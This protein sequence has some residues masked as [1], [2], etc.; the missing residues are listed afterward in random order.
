MSLTNKRSAA[1]LA[2][3]THWS[4]TKK[5]RNEKQTAPEREVIEV[6]SDSE[7]EKAAVTE[8]TLAL[9]ST[10]HLLHNPSYESHLEE[11]VNKD[12]IKISDLIGSQDLRESYQFNFTVQLDLILQYF[13]K[14]VSIHRKRITFITGSTV[15]DPDNPDIDFI[16]QKF[17][18][19]DITASLPNA[20]ASHHTKMMINF[21]EDNTCEV[22]IMTFNL[23]KIDFAG[24][25]QMLWRSGRLKKLSA[26]TIEPE[27]G[28]WFK[29]DLQRYLR[30]YGKKEL[31][32]LAM[33]LG[34]YDFLPVEVELV[35]SV[36]G[37]NEITN[38]KC[39]EIY[40][41][42]KL[43]QILNRNN[44]KVEK[45]ANKHHNILS[46]VSSIPYPFKI[47]KGETSSVFTH[48]LCPLAFAPSAQVFSILEPGTRSCTKHQEAHNYKP[49][50]IYPTVEEVAASNVGWASGQALHFNYTKSAAHRNQYEQN[51][52]PYLKRWSNSGGDLVTGRETVP[53]HVKMLICDN[54][55][56]WETIRW[57]LMGSHNLSKQAWGINNG[58]NLSD[59]TR[60]TVSSYE[61][62]VLVFPRKDQV[63]KPVYA[64][65][66][67]D[68]PNVLPLRLPFRLPTED[69]KDSDRPFSQW[70]SYGELQDKFGN[71]Y[72]LDDGNKK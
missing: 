48:I 72:N 17:N 24:L 51:I 7:D 2:A 42:G 29:K 59:P 56:D 16:K 22:V 39:S 49:H 70:I 36:P 34:E 41:Y 30:K 13:H 11:Y 19:R 5:A 27:V 9:K 28:L 15:L 47:R 55:N 1:F 62:G 14:D 35:A 43:S 67:T 71:S 63:M 4:G 46:Q 20:F 69:Y 57:A 32:S 33:E 6:K 50:I 53:P 65:D 60:Y 61:L 25:T 8:P 45:T 12:T 66:S 23:T 38:D 52:K 40:G 31:R 68:E 18:I 58:T 54:G 3:S 64:T 26:S 37:S 21:F 10:I 44:L